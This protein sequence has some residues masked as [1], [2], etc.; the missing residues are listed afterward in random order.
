MI[1]VGLINELNFISNSLNSKIGVELTIEQLNFSL[2]IE[3]DFLTITHEKEVV[4]EESLDKVVGNFGVESC[5]HIC[6]ILLK[7]KSNEPYKHLIY[8]NT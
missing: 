4:W 3:K 1:T 7:K 6:L 8:K 5:Q 2:E